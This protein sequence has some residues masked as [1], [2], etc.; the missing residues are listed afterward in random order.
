MHNDKGLI[1]QEDIILNVYASYDRVTKWMRQKLVELKGEID[2]SII[3]IGTSTLFNQ[4]WQTQQAENE[5]EHS[6]IEQQHQLTESKDIYRL[7]Y[8]RTAEYTLFP[9]SLKTFSK[10]DHIL[11]HKNAS[12]TFKR[13]DIIQSILRSQWN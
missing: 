1:L 4:Y 8:P 9:S 5:L 3:V 10:I 12:N 7:F 13:I 11:D 6:L 2:E